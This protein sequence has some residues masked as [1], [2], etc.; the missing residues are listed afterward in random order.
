MVVSLLKKLIGGNDNLY[1]DDISEII[2]NISKFNSN[3]S[4]DSE[5]IKNIIKAY[6]I[7]EKAHGSQLR[8]SGEPYFTHCSKVGVILSEWN[9]DIDMIVAGLLHDSIEDTELNLEEIE[10]HFNSDISSLVDGVS[11][12]SGIKFSS[13]KEEQAENF[14][15]MFLSVAEDIRVIIIKFAD[16][17]HN[18]RTIDFLPLIKQRRIA[19][20]TKEIFSPLAHRLGMNNVK[21]EMDDLILKI[22]DPKVYKQLQ[23]KVKSTKNQSDAIIKKFSEPLKSELEKYN[24]HSDV[25]GRVKNYSSIY[26]KM[27]K[28]NKQFNEIY[29]IFAIRVRVEKVEEC[30]AV[31]GIVHQIYT[32]IQERFKD[33]IATPKGNGYQSIHTTVFGEKGKLI[34]VQIRTK[35]MDNT[36]EVGIAAHWIYKENNS[37]SDNELHGLNKHVT[38]LRELVENLKDEDRNPS[39]FFKILKIDLFQ[40]EIF[41]FTPNGD[42]VQLNNGSTPIDFGFS[43]HTQVGMHCIGAKVN[44]KIVPLNTVLK[45]GDTVEIITSK[46][47][48]PSH[49]WLK[50]VKTAKAKAHIKRWVKKDENEQSIKL[51]KEMIEKTLRRLKKLKILDMI[52]ENPITMGFNNEEMIFADVA[53]GHISIRDIIKKYEPEKDNGEAKTDD[54]SLAQRFLSKARGISKGVSVGGISNAMITFAKCCNPIPGDEIVGYITK[55]RGVSVHRSTCG[56]MPILENENRFIDVEWNVSSESSFVVRLNISAID[57][58]HLL[59]DVSEKVSSMNIYI[60]SIDMRANDG[61]ASC[62]LV[63]QIRNTKQLERLFRALKQLNHV[64][65]VDRI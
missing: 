62:V 12:L 31:L 58:K 56:N 22:L 40:D 1:S 19:N 18:L 26:R 59:K 2:K 65:S 49:A 55:G 34:E 15:K 42:V 38:W 28:L 37:T 20:E 52:T 21:I 25:Y 4:E 11:K 51:G 32:P 44:F 43:V 60:Q 41:V 24:I 6:D 61:L 50:F 53:K 27:Q 10:E 29:D 57:R 48:V 14:M 16:R 30:Y 7:G 8:K 33:Y 9:M 3:I 63:V 54:E 13:R 5:F 64:I 17:L 39:E 46:K 36:A 35:K 23:K 45:N 47:Q